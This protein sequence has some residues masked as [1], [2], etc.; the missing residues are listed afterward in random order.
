MIK[1]Q[2]IFVTLGNCS[3]LTHWLPEKLC[4]F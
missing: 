4:H 3:K 1:T 2:Q